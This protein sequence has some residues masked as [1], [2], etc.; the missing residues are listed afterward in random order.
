MQQ[1]EQAM[2]AAQNAQQCN[3]QGMG[4]PGEGQSPSTLDEYATMY[5]QMLQAQ[6]GGGAGMGMGMQGP[7]TG[8]GGKAP[9]K[10]DEQMS[11]QAT[12]VN[13]DFRPR[14]IIASWK[15]EGEAERGEQTKD[16]EHTIPTRPQEVSEAILREQI[17]AGYHQGIRDFFQASQPTQGPE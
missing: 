12:R 1:L 10:P 16:Y 8:E 13:S 15:T 2:Q 11:S 7:G 4:K 9:E 17:P 6:G 5:Q 3:A 14:D